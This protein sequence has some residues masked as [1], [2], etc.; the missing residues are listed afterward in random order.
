[1]RSQQL[2]VTTTCAYLEARA[3]PQ[4]PAL[5]EESAVCIP[6]MVGVVCFNTSKPRWMKKE[7]VARLAGVQIQLGNQLAARSLRSG[8]STSGEC[9]AGTAAA[10]GPTS[11]MR[12]E[13]I[14]CLI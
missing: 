6:E 10:E 14:R 2:H 5:E 8:G 11:A 12:G 1:M 4:A 3:G 7:E 9:A 13:A